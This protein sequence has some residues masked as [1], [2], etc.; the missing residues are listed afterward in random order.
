VKLF[1]QE[2]YIPLTE[3]GNTLLQRRTVSYFKVAQGTCESNGLF[4]IHQ[5][6]VCEAAALLLRE[7]DSTPKIAKMSPLRSGGCYVK[8]GGTLWLATANQA[9][10]S[11]G[12]SPNRQIIC[13]SKEFPTTETT[14]PTTI[15]TT[16]TT[17]AKTSKHPSLFCWCVAMTVKS[18]PLQIDTEV[19][20]MRA[21]YSRNAGLFN[22]DGWRVFSNEVVPLDNEGKVMTSSIPGPMSQKVA[23]PN[24]ESEQMLANTGVFFRAW[25][26][27]LQKRLFDGYDWTIKL[28]P[29]AVFFP[30]RLR[31]HLK[32]GWYKPKYNMYFKNCQRWN[33]MQGPLEI[34][35]H[36]AM[37]TFTQRIGECKQAIDCSKIGEDIFM[38]KCTQQL[39]VEGKAEWTMLNDRYCNP[40]PNCPCS[41][42]WTVAFHPFKSIQAYAQCEN[43]ANN[44]R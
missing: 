8:G 2:G 31:K 25:D 27:V 3:N 44:A 41:N 36:T 30:E 16:A 9:A 42:G 35:S 38:Q 10:P 11:D 5:A 39:G 18:G 14:A 28:D 20:L 15:T 4:P 21:T 26:K 33:S 17:V 7:P 37:T 43:E 34:Y 40:C 12:A 13:T 22:C 6:E 23:I 32:V 1:R 29:D 19:A 24:M